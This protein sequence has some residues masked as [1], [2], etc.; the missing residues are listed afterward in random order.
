M[1]RRT[2]RVI[3]NCYLDPEL[4]EKKNVARYLINAGIDSEKFRRNMIGLLGAKQMHIRKDFK[5]R[6]KE[7]RI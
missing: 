4:E 7:M 6:R 1:D 5:N 3:I 2:A